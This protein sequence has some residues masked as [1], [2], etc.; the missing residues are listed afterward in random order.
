MIDGMPL[1][2]SFLKDGIRKIDF[3]DFDLDL[4]E[5]EVGTALPSLEE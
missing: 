4:E 5:V 2:L 3:V 1:F